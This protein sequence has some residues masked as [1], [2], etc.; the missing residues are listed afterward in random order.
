MQKQAKDHLI[1]TTVMVPCRNEQHFIANCLDSIIAQDYPKDKLEILVVD[2]ASNDKTKEII[3]E[4]ALKYSFVKLLNNAKKVVPAALNMAV[5]AAK[6]DIIMRMDAHCIYTQDYISKCVQ[7][8]KQHD[9]VD[10]VGGICITLPGNNTLLSQSIALA[11]SHPFGVGNS[12]FRIGSKKERYVDT[13]PFGCYKRKVF[14]KNGLFDEDLIR[15]QDSEFNARLLK[16]GGRI[17]LV[18]EIISYYYARDSLYALWKMQFQY[19]YFKP[20]AAKKIGRI[21]APRHAV[22][23]LFIG[24]LI[25]SFVF[26]PF[27]KF[28][29]WYFLFALFFYIVVDLG[30]S[31]AIS[32]KKKFKCFC[33]LPLIFSVIHFAW[34]IGFLKGTLDFVIFKK[35]KKKR[36]VDPSPTR[37]R[38][39]EKIL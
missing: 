25:I 21:F 1:F 20:L 2:G 23:P 33:I 18:P 13:V 32:L 12:Y 35:D 16:N 7:R 26:S 8:L 34:G 22:P 31:L 27:F 28:F 36:N 29:L 37:E 10:N 4:Y 24:S 39:S 19:G 11:L 17:L 9:E 3:S 30:V 15:T 38:C 14:L 5:K 6:G